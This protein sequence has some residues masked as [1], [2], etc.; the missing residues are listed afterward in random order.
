MYCSHT[1]RQQADD[2]L[3]STD[4]C[5]LEG[6]IAFVEQLVGLP[7]FILQSNGCRRP[8]VVA[9]C[10]EVRSIRKDTAHNVCISG[11]ALGPTRFVWSLAFPRRDPM[12]IDPATQALIG[13]FG[14]VHVRE[15]YSGSASVTCLPPRLLPHT[16]HRPGDNS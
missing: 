4:V 1:T 12:P 10:G 2:A 15:E 13:G 16:L 11:W 14:S 5:L 8:M 6:S 3:A 7:A 9:S